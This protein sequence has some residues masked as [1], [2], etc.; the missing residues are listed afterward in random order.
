PFPS[1][2]L[3]R[4]LLDP[5]GCD[6]GVILTSKDVMSIRKSVTSRARP[7]TAGGTYVARQS[8]ECERA[9]A[10][11]ARERADTRLM[12][13]ATGTGA[14]ACLAVVVSLAVFTSGAAVSLAA[15]PTVRRAVGVRLGRAIR[16]EM[17]P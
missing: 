15:A 14:R 13:R 6:V 3:F 17:R 4:S 11:A 1:T 7:A 9:R 5:P 10:T 8:V 2:T 16:Q 12:R